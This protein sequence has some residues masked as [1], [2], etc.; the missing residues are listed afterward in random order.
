MTAPLYLDDLNIGDR[1]T[2]P[3]YTLEKDQLLEFAGEYDPQPFH[4]DDELAKDTLFNGLAASGWQTASITMKL[5]TETLHIANG[6]IGIDC[7]LKWPTPT[8]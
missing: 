1:F 5:W 2:S 8:R 4:L 6:L 7:H 3:A